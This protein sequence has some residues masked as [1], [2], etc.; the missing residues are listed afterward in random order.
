MKQRFIFCCI[1]FA[2]LL[3]VLWCGYAVGFYRG[4]MQT[5]AQQLDFDLSWNVI[6]YKD[7]K[8]AEQDNLIQTRLWTR[9]MNNLLNIIYGKLCVI[10]RYPNYFDLGS[11]DNK[12]FAKTV[13]QARDLTRG[14]ERGVIKE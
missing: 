13:E 8:I 4:S 2:A 6:L 14:I 12:E 7:L 10:D 9:D 5:M 1:G 3:V 11:Q